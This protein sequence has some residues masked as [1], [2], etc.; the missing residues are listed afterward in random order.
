VSL[1]VA[2]LDVV[3]RDGRQAL[4]RVSLRVREGEQV[5]VI[6]PS[7]A[8]KT[9]LLR[10]AGA[11]L[12]PAQGQVEVLGRDPWRM[13]AG[14]LRRL[15]AQLGMV[16]QSPPIPP[17]LRVVTAVLSGRLGQWSTMRALR[18]LL[19][20]VDIAGAREALAR[21]DMADR[22]FDRCDRLSGGQ[23][24]R[25]GVARV[26]Y[27]RPRLLLADEPVSA[28]DPALSDSTLEQ[29]VMQ[30]RETGA[31]LFASL[32]AVDLALKWFPRIIGMREGEVVFD[33]PAS[34]V[35]RPMLL[36]LYASEG[37]GLPTQDEEARPPEARP[38][39]GGKVVPLV[40]PRC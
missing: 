10:V 35:T 27:Q 26:L 17:R 6:G 23:L 12:R 28:L 38:K 25:V 20:P 19:V 24:Q 13:V 18:S 21:V 39:H 5:A 1:A 34:Q 29:L 16:H 8:G 4:K 33:L 9:S 15:R 7:G 14:E 36:Q 3:F 31:T 11:A 22:L 32:H 30:S 2:G 40:R 37:R